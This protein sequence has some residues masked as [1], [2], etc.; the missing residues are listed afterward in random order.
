MASTEHQIKSEG[1]AHHERAHP[2]QV[3]VCGIHQ[4]YGRLSKVG[5]ARRR[6][7]VH[8]RRDHC[9]AGCIFPCEGGGEGEGWSGNG[10]SFQRVRLRVS[11]LNPI[12]WQ[13]MGEIKSHA[14]SAILVRVAH[15]GLGN[16]AD[17]CVICSSAYLLLHS[18][19]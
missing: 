8:H 19:L 18:T 6:H 11:D 2:T 10:H 16:I 14:C 3:C 9:H 15:A 7:A 17:E 13:L 12:V 5:H 4:W 1:G